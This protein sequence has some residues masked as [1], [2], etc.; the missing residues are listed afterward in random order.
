M[1]KTIL[2]LNL[3]LLLGNLF[4][5]SCR[6]TD[7]LVKPVP[8]NPPP[9]L[10]KNFQLVID[11]IPGE[12]KA[13]IEALFAVFDVTTD[14]GQAVLSNKKLALTYDGKFKT[15][16]LELPAGKYK[17]SKLVLQQ[18]NQVRF[19][20]PMANSA[21][22]NKVT[23]PLPVTF[24][25]PQPVVSVI[26]VQVARIETGDKPQDFGY[27][28]GTFEPLP[29]Q[30]G[31]PTAI[32][33][34]LRLAVQVGEIR[35]DSIPGTVLYTT[36]DASQPISGRYI[37]LAAG[38]NKLTLDKNV[39]K[40]HFRIT[41]WGK[42]YELSLLQ[43]EVE[44]G[45]TY[46]MGGNQQAKML[47]SEITS[48]LVNGNYVAESKTSYTYHSP[49]KLSRIDYYLKRDNS[50]YLA[51]HELFTYAGDRV[52]KIERYDEKKN[53][54]GYTDFTYN[55]A[56][57]ISGIS[58]LAGERLTKAS[59]TRHAL[60]GSEFTDLSFAFSYSHTANGM[61]YYQRYRNGNRVSDNSNTDNHNTE[62]GSYDYDNNIN[63]YAH[64]GWPDLFL[65]NHS[66]NNLV[67]QQKTFYGNYPTAVA[68]DFKYKYDAEG[69]PV[70][71]IRHYRS[72]ITN[73]FLFTT[74]TVFSY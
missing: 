2:K 56:G 6:K 34:N 71:L 39:V 38:T 37:V 24:M 36:W 52:E 23:R 4:F 48:K 40:H 58:E 31:E 16:E 66:K 14:D 72:A 49:G 25:L 18:G 59:I 10:S 28:V 57:Q 7:D 19:I 3:I 68:Y 35:Y 33:I 1:K 62:T 12:P 44:N 5:A 21:R 51:K 45:K 26:D 69:Y 15:G 46:V 42:V 30:P 53:L 32:A 17:V 11:S 67:W 55:A 27:P 64:M 54:S 43:S 13:P 60:P 70:E 61:R 41:K 74:K 50:P 20:A 8:Q 73:Q 22:S 65:V 63:P 9:V 29:Q 47:K